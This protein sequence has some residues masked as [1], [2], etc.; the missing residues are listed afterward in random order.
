MF[1]IL[2]NAYVQILVF[3]SC[4][5]ALHVGDQSTVGAVGTSMVRDAHRFES[6]HG[7][8]PGLQATPKTMSLK[9]DK[10]HPWGH[11]P[12]DKILTRAS[13]VKA[14]ASHLLNRIN[15]NVIKP[16]AMTLLA[17]FRRQEAFED[18]IKFIVFKMHSG[19]NYRAI[20]M[21]TNKEEVDKIFE[22]VPGP[23]VR[24]PY[25]PLLVLAQEAEDDPSD[26]VYRVYVGISNAEINLPKMAIPETDVDD[27]MAKLESGAT[28]QKWTILTARIKR[29]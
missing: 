7:S 9:Y 26:S 24:D 25:H 11:L 15:A 13:R 17:G 6:E 1:C 2:P 19:A 4:V 3:V 21:N 14:R 12:S 10:N 18:G 20:Y 22:P 29:G 8:W 23:E 28:K 27:L 16:H 5:G